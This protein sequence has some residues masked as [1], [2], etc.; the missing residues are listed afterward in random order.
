MQVIFSVHLSYHHCHVSDYEVNDICC[1][2][3]SDL[4]N[5]LSCSFFLIIKTCKNFVRLTAW[6]YSRCVASN[7]SST[8]NIFA[9]YYSIISSWAARSLHQHNSWA[10]YTELLLCLSIHTCIS[11]DFS[12]FRYYNCTS[13]VAAEC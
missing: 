12:I 7:I 3:W 13:W 2:Y 11:D 5:N 6:C 4:S 1:T 8:A 9:F 10:I